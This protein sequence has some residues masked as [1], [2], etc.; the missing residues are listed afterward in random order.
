MP[1]SLLDL[2]IVALNR[3]YQRVAMKTLV[4]WAMEGRI[5]AGDLVREA[6]GAWLSVLD[7]PELA[8][9]M[10]RGLSTTSGVPGQAAASQEADAEGG[11]AEDDADAVTQWVAHRP[12]RR[13]EEA[14]MDM[15]PMIDVTFQLLIFFMLTNHL[16]NPAPTLVPEAAHG[17]GVDPQGRQM[18]VIDRDG[19]YYFG[20]AISRESKAASL[21]ALVGE[22]RGNAAAA[23]QPL[24]VIVS[25]HKE[26]KYRAVRELVERLGTVENVGKI[27]VGVEEKQ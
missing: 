4:S 6:D 27:L 13:G 21:D 20:D 22:V 5:A 19:S 17:Q 9:S 7:I 2:K 15:T 26:A 1:A 10:P 23:P 8:A 18:I 11:Q 25:G 24:E 3:V 14:E 16:Q 12:R